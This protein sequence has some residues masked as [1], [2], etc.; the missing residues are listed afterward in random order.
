MRL[1]AQ[2]ALILKILRLEKKPV[3]VARL[4][5]SRLKKLRMGPSKYSRDPYLRKIVRHREQMAAYASISRSLR[6]L[7]KA[8]LISMEYYRPPTDK[9][10]PKNV[11]PAGDA[12]PERV[13]T[14]NRW[15]RLS[16]I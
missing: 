15:V 4:V 5:K 3:S 16:P 12:L 1:S 14:G 7:E 11:R 10:D 13:Y 6:K 2:Q 8:G 9:D